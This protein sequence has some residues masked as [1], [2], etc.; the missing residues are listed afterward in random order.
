MILCDVNVL[1][2]AHREET[3]DHAAYADWLTRV[4]TG[5]QAFAISELVLSGFVRVATHPKVFDPPSPLGSA[6]E[7]AERLRERPNA[8][9]IA[10]GGSAASRTATAWALPE[11]CAFQPAGA[12]W[13]PVARTPR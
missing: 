8:T 2:Y 4:A 1:V 10:P 12:A 13:R 7:F 6:L 9:P 5:P 11:G 3:P